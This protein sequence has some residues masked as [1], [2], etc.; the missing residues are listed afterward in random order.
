MM[1][2][3]WG[4]HKEE[5]F[6]VDFPGAPVVKNLPANAGD[7]GS[8]PGPGRSHMLWDDWAHPPATCTLEPVLHEKSHHSE[9]PAHHDGQEPH[10]W[11]PEKA[12]KQQRPRTAKK[13]QVQ[14]Y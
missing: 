1:V 6:C 9:R 11:Q 2:T 8:I 5:Y 13:N 14:I 3:Q 4:L 7:M 10:V 12:H